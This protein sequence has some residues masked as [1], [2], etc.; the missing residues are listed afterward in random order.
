MKDEFGGEEHAIERIRAGFVKQD[1]N[2]L[3]NMTLEGPLH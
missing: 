2:N 3:A 1:P